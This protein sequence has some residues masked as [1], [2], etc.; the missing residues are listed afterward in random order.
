MKRLL[1]ILLPLLM[2]GAASF[3]GSSQGASTTETIG[4]I[5]TN[6]ISMA[7]RI[8]FVT[9]N[10]SVQFELTTSV[11]SVGN[12]PSFAFDTVNA[13]GYL[14]VNISGG[15]GAF[16]VKRL[17]TYHPT[18]SWDSHVVVLDRQ[19]SSTNQI[20]WYTNG[21][22]AGLTQVSSYGNGGGTTAFKVDRLY[23][24]ARNNG[25]L[26][27]MNGFLQD[28]SIFAGEV[29][30]A[31]AYMLGSQ[32]MSPLKVRSAKLINYWPFSAGENASNSPDLV[33]GIPVNS[34]TKSIVLE[35]APTYRK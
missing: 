22:S 6:L 28:V 7:F 18:G 19:S 23:F 5:G 13:P 17:N 24:G 14:D 4:G 10:A 11:T 20:R 8:R 35:Q 21:V 16:H 3:N 25:S 30:A 15:S 33:G 2:C 31:E 34:G 26:Y 12:T 29:S 27:R 1:L 9:T 32:R